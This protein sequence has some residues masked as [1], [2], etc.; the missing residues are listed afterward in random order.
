VKYNTAQP[1]IASYV[2]LRKDGKIAFVLR[3]NTAWMN[4]YYGLPSGKVEQGEPFSK[5]ALREAF[6]EAGVEISESNLSHV[7]TMHRK[8]AEDIDNTWVDVFFE[9]IQY[10]GEP[11]NAEPHVHDELAW[12]DPDNLP[13][14]IIPSVRAALDFIAAGERFAEWG[15]DK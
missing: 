15:W 3:S 6:E 1:Y 4:G 11:Y 8:E 12:L 14:N 5:A 13:E 7:L 9:A 10:E 2:I